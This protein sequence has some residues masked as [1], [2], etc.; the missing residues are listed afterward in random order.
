MT[1]LL[2]LTVANLTGCEFFHPTT[3]AEHV[4][5]AKELLAKG[6]L[7]G[8]VLELK[9]AL[10]KNPDHGEARR[11]LGDI[12]AKWGDGPS[13][14][15]ELRRAMELG[16]EKAA[17]SL[18]LAEALQ[19][20]GKNQPILDEIGMPTSPN[21]S[22]R[23]RLF[24]YRG[25][26]W[27]GLN[28][29]DRA[30]TEYEL[31]L[32]IDARSAFAKLGLARLAAAGNEWDKALQ[33]AK[34][35]AEAAPTEARIWSFQAELYKSKGDLEQAE[36]S[37][38]KAIGLRRANQFDRVNRA[39]LQ[40]QMNKTEEAAKDIEIL[41][42]QTPNF[43]LVHYASGLLQ[44]AQNHYPEAQEAFDQV[45]TLNPR[46]VQARY[47]HALSHFYQ[48]HTEQAEDSLS[49]FL[50]AYPQ[51]IQGIKLMALLHYQQKD[52]GEAKKYIASVVAQSPQ[53]AFSLK[54]LA[55]IEFA[56]GNSGEG[57]LH[58]QQLTELEPNSP[59]A[60]AQL[61]VGLLGAGQQ[62]K[63]L[64]ALQAAVELDPNL[65]Q[66]EI[67][68]AL[69]HIR[70]KQFVQAQATIEK[71]KEKM[72]KSALPLDLEGMAYVFKDDLEKA[73]DSFE[74]A[75]QIA[76]KDLTAATSLAQFALREKNADKATE[77]Y[78]QILK[79]HPK[80]IPAYMALAGIQAVNGKLRETEDYLKRAMEA[81]PKALH[82]RVALAGLYIRLGQGSK[83]LALL[84][85]VR[86]EHGGNPE[87]LAALVEAQL[88]NHHAVH[89]M[90]TAKN[91][92]KGSPKSA[93][94]HY[95]LARAYA[96]NNDAKSM[97]ASLEES[98]KLDPKLFRSRL[99][100]I[101]LLSQEKKVDE[102]KKNLASLS[103]EFPE[104][105]EVLELQGWF[106][107]QQ[108]KPE[109]A[110]KAYQSALEKFPN[111]QFAVHLAQ[112]QWAAGRKEAA[113][114]TMEQ[115][116]EKYP[117]D[118]AVRY[119]LSIRYSS[120]GHPEKARAELSAILK[121]NPNHVLALNDLAWMV[122]KEDSKEAL[123]YAEKAI[124]L[125]PKSPLVMD[126][127]AMVLLET[128]Q[129]ER[130]L[131]VIEEANQLTQKIPDI[132]YH[133]AQAYEKNGRSE[134]AR[135]VLAELLK[136]DVQFKEKKEAEQLLNRLR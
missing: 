90:E 118:T 15:K 25:D 128:G 125:K 19:L 120:S 62:E 83:S 122:R 65:V 103:G 55:N 123:A 115:W 93:Q 32:G 47:F 77:L 73:K 28:K 127:L 97:R 75:L 46:Y 78:Q 135:K 100:M 112:S 5:E 71:L 29:P 18:P 41:K 61:G 12:Y 107:M 39:L 27:M 11:L 44:L 84:E 66:A 105:P 88:E 133:L 57:L 59:T 64:E 33:L 132:R 60:Q 102:A 58:L 98:L 70:N 114:A 129:N 43:Y 85:D 4:A 87:F 30:K 113:L 99:A 34:E 38:G 51:S 13:A 110:V 16:V 21:A 67:Y 111:S 24:A 26:A 130:A 117:K 86:A 53:D 7:N 49:K 104:S 92:V 35:A 81:A 101:R 63:G 10:Q 121:V 134:D 68:I 42:K 108:R 8:S 54:L 74:K 31:A 80:H 136:E 119:L 20:Q 72:P 14:E 48:Q 116:I 22:D 2:S 95:L 3:D 50:Y 17:V 40:I 36:A 89:A 124:S 1:I 23:S 37:Y 76:P 45:L 6:K 79:D 126:T 94:A 69:T 109:E 96:E 131:G 9:N 56:L 82:P 106:A 52:Y 91:L